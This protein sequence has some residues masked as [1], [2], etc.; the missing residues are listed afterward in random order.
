MSLDPSLWPSARA[1][2][3][4]RRIAVALE[5]LASRHGTPKLKPRRKVEFSVA[6]T[7]LFNKHYQEEQDLDLLNGEGEERPS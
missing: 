4:L 3:I 5:S 6:T 2:A 1:L 7:D